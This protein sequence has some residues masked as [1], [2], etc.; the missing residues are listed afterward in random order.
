MMQALVWADWHTLLSV[1]FLLHF[2]YD[3]IW[4]IEIFY[5]IASDVSLWHPPEAVAILQA[6]VE[7]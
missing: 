4:Y 2:V 3:L 5:C 1:A 6:Q 7:L